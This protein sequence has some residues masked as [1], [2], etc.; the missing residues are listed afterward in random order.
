MKDINDFLQ[1]I[2]FED[3][4]YLTA[5]LK[6]YLEQMGYQWKEEQIIGFRM[7]DDYTDDYTDWFV[8][9]KGDTVIAIP[10]STKPG[11]YWRN[12]G[13]GGTQ[14]EGQTIGMW[15]KGNTAWSGLPY[16]QQIKP[17]TCYRDHSKLDHIDRDAPLD[18]GNFENNFHSWKGI[19]EDGKVYNVS[20]MCQ[21]TEPEENAAAFELLKQ[22][23]D[24]NN[25]N[26]TLIFTGAFLS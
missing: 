21:V 2:L 3:T 18:T 24:L 7:D 4:D 16:L 12:L 13:K 10:G 9:I 8:I 5:G 15:A 1:V 19:G 22:F 20:E 23:D 26:Y 6:A 17:C 11:S 25:I 14:K